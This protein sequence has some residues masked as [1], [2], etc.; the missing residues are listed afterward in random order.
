[1]GVSTRVP[2]SRRQ[3]GMGD[4]KVGLDV[5]ARHWSQLGELANYLRGRG[6][7]LIPGNAPVVTVAAGGSTTLRYRVAPSGRAIARLWYTEI[8]SA[9]ATQPARATISVTGDS[10]DINSTLNS[11]GWLLETPV[12]KGTAEVEL[13]LTVACNAAS[14]QSVIVQSVHCWELHRAQ[15]TKDATDL[16]VDLSTLEY[17][18]PIWDRDYEAIA[19]VADSIAASNGR[20]CGLVSWY[21]PEASFSGAA[22]D[23][24]ELP[25]RVVPPKI[26]ASDT[27]RTCTWN[28]YAYCSDGTTAGT[29]VVRDAAG[30][31][32][33]A[34]TVTAGTTSPTWFTGGSKSLLC[35]DLSQTDGLPSGAYETV[36]VRCA[37]TAGAG[38]VRLIGFNLYDSATGW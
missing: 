4:V 21:G 17:N 15:L 27:T 33:G 23:L 28:V 12:S 24:F 6:S 11:E 25:I 14:L 36:Q 7:V 18:R 34:L 16:A 26:G 35:E 29:V 38:S 31:D 13:A 3:V 22:A 1:M 20:R 5:S 30:V 10:M 2:A 32:S 19:A 8:V 9:S 37:R